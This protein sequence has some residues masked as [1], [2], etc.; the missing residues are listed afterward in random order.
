MRGWSL[1]LGAG[2]LVAIILGVIALTR[3]GSTQGQLDA[4]SEQLRSLSNLSDLSSRIDD[5]SNRIAGVGEQ[6]SGL[7]VESLSEQLGSLG[8]NLA[9][10][11][12][13]PPSFDSLRSMS[14]AEIATSLFS[15]VNAEGYQFTWHYET[16]PPPGFYRGNPPHG[17]ILRAYLNN[18]AYDAVE[19]KLGTFPPGSIIVKENHAPG[20]FVL[21][22]NSE[23]R[24]V[25]GFAGNLV[26]TT[27]MVKIE[28][29][30][31]DVGDWFWAKL[32]P[33]G[34]ID[35]AGKPEGCIACHGAVA[36]NDYVYDAQVTDRT[37]ETAP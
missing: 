31:P 32:Q 17:G 37:A 12:G 21:D 6:V 27:I 33:D 5:L 28:G 19:R 23:D 3:Q 2:V 10:G 1:V 34:T 18:I 14:D 15:L 36:A 7:G 24:R 8:S 13:A 30:N 16:D 22:P 35:A 20:D 4:I 11:G 25:E 26:A 29:Y 9:T